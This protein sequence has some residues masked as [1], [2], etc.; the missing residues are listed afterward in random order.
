[1]AMIIIY[2]YKNIDNCFVSTSNAYMVI[3]AKLSSTL[4]S[5]HETFEMFVRQQFIFFILNFKLVI[6]IIIIT[7]YHYYF[8]Y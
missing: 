1:M 2:G 6:I 8:Y 4:I 3:A 5:Q 7:D